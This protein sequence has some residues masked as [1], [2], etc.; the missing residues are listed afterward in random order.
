M[1]EPQTPSTVLRTEQASDTMSNSI[2]QTGL[3]G[4]LF[5]KGCISFSKFSN[6]VCLNHLNCCHAHFL[7]TVKWLVL[8]SFNMQTTVTDHRNL[9]F[10]ACLRKISP[11]MTVYLGERLI[12]LSQ[13]RLNRFQTL[14]TKF[15]LIFFI[16]AR[17][18]MLSHQFARLAQ[19]ISSAMNVF[20]DDL[21]FPLISFSDIIEK[22]WHVFSSYA[23]S[24]IKRKKNQ[25]WPI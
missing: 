6:V 7:K 11:W 5:T 3:R 8:M 22:T 21:S 20:V 2:N 25:F 15:L 23:L 17:W 14:K 16:R 24:K 12:L 4:F 10:L 13:E 18:W 1:V 19:K 9:N